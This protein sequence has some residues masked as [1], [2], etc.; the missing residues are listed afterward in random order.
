VV[1]RVTAGETTVV[2]DPETDRLAVFDTGDNTD[3]NSTL[4]RSSADGATPL[5]SSDG[6]TPLASSEGET[7][8]ASSEGETPLVAGTVS[9]LTT[10][11]GSQRSHASLDTSVAVVPAD[12]AVDVTVTV[13]NTSAEPVELEAIRPFDGAQTA[14]WSQ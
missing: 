14:F 3:E 10:A 2:H 13:E 9:A 4:S 12:G 8:L 7:P 1:R 6:E 11:S 5:A